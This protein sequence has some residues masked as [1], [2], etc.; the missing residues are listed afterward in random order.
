MSKKTADQAE[1]QEQTK[2]E[3]TEDRVQGQQEAEGEAEQAHESDQ[4]GALDGLDEE[5]EEL[6][7]GVQP[8]PTEVK[9]ALE[10]EYP[11]LR[12]HG[13]HDAAMKGLQT[14]ASGSY[15]RSKL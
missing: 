14:D 4:E 13:T 9:G 12:E 15:D 10:A 3:M 2:E 7:E 6:P 1:Q 8:L 5:E 11:V